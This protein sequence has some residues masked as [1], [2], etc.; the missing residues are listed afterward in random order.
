MSIRDNQLM[1]LGER[2]AGQRERGERR[3]RDEGDSVV[4]DGSFDVCITRGAV[5]QLDF[6]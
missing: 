5:E 4:G 1:R 2:A 6:Q 3:G